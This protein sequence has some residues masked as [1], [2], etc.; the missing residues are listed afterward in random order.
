MHGF[1]EKKSGKLVRVN[2]EYGE[3]IEDITISG[4]FFIH[5]EESLELIE[6]RLRG[7]RISE[8]HDV[9]GIVSDLIWNNHIELIGITPET[10]SEAIREAV[11][12]KNGME[13]DRA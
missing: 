3:K 8:L 7:L 12:G 4:D 11:S 5:P 6:K 2:I 9:S 10:I 13:N 1:A